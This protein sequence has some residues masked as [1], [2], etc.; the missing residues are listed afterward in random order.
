LKPGDRIT[1]IDGQELTAE[2]DLA[3]M[4]QA[5]QP[6][7]EI[8][9]TVQRLGEAED[10]EVQVTL[11]EN[12]DQPKQ[13]YLG[14][15]YQPLPEI[16]PGEGRPWVPLPEWPGFEGKILPFLPPS[17]AAPFEFQKPE[18]PEGI[19][20]AAIIGQVAEG[21]PAEAAGL[22]QGDLI[23]ALDGEPVADAGA[24]A[25]AI[26]NHRP[27]EEI[28]L[29]VNRLASSE[30]A[31]GEGAGGS[32]GWAE[33]LSIDVTLG[34]NPEKEGQGYLGVTV[35]GFIRIQIE[36]NPGPDA[37]F[38]PRPEDDPGISAQLET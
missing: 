15:T 13:A 1:A 37:F 5:R 4:I 6:G 35:Q 7:E 28:T 25:E 33:P 10:R 12:P 36:E 17:G 29:T 2:T 11:G 30:D 3:K 14:V 16:S 38:W 19:D 8:S 21:S 26:R 34:E 27:G 23:T 20:S 31:G 9:L 18:L 24:L 32:A 22:Q